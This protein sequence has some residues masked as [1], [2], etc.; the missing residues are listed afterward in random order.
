[1]HCTFIILKNWNQTSIRPILKSNST[2]FMFNNIFC[3]M[4]IKKGIH[5]GGVGHKEWGTFLISS[6]KCN[7][8][9]YLDIQVYYFDIL[10]ISTFMP[11]IG[12]RCV[13]HFCEVFADV[14]TIYFTALRWIM[15]EW[16]LFE[17][18]KI[19]LLWTR[20]W[21]L[22]LLGKWI[23]YTFVLFVLTICIKKMPGVM[24]IDMES[25]RTTMLTS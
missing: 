17:T 2:S 19:Q 24:S 23:E 16:D 8:S 18:L 14:N 4:N 25:V 5:W 9:I 6:Y 7:Y 20:I 11:S 12:S 21:I 3:E 10:A 1:M 15:N 22:I 13:V